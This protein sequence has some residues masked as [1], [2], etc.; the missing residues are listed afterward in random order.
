MVL[1]LYIDLAKAFDTVDHK[2]LLSKLSHYGIRGKTLSW[3]ENYLNERQQFVKYSNVHSQCKSITCCV[4][5]GSIMGPLLFLLY[6]NDLSSV[7][8]RLLSFMF[9]HDTSMLIHGKDV[10]LLEKEMNRELCKVTTWLKANKLSL[11]I[12]KTHSMLFS[13]SPKCTGRKNLIEIDGV[14][15][16]TVNW[17]KFLGII[18]DN[19]L[20][21][22]QHINELC[23][24]VAKGIGINRKVRHILNRK[25]LINLYYTFIFP[26][27]SYCNI[28]WGRAANDHL[29]RI[30]LLQKKILR[31]IFNVVYREYTA[32]LFME[33]KIMTIY[34]L[35]YYM[36]CI[37]MYKYHHSKLPAIYDNMFITNDNVLGSG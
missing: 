32:P 4:P 22:T 33:S 35:N 13:N 15:I 26:Y 8:E 23:N 20:T 25:S 9:A 28:V 11:N 5:Q 24:K 30:F 17:T 19:K 12:T 10:S 27:L 37:F 21:W 3:F 1:Y 34:Q 7:S 2:I 31:C 29:S 18:V 6:I 36:V 16:E 14:I